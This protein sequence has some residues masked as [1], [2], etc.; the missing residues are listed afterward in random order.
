MIDLEPA[1]GGDVNKMLL[2]NFVPE[3]DFAD[4]DDD[5]VFARFRAQSPDSAI[6]PTS[7]AY[8]KLASEQIDG[9]QT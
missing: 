9:S 6:S 1:D 5:S 3:Y 2:G 8:S 7:P 4:T